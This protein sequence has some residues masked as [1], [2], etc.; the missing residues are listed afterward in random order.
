M[1]TRLSLCLCLAALAACEDDPC[2][3]GPMTEGAG[4]V[5]VTEDEHPTGWGQEDCAACHA[6][7]ALHRMNCTPEV[8]L[9][10]V[11]DRVDA[12]G[13]ASC[14]ECH[15]WNGLPEPT[16]ATTEEVTE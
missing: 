5:V 10:E 6:F 4:G 3:R 1:V 11:Q 13:V 12:D 16:P 14:S 7:P 8:D 15:G 9:V 2:P